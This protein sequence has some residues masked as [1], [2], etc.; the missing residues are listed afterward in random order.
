MVNQECAE[1]QALQVKIILLTQKCIILSVHTYF[2]CLKAGCLQLGN[3]LQPS[4][5][6]RRDLLSNALARYIKSRFFWGNITLECISVGLEVGIHLKFQPD[7][8]EGCSPFNESN[9]KE[10]CNLTVWFG[11]IGSS[12]FSS[13]IILSNFFLLF[14]NLHCPRVERKKWWSSRDQMFDMFTRVMRDEMTR[15]TFALHERAI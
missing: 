9:L 15:M 13:S 3:I 6:L 5:G 7:S 2:F 14:P 1:S 12:S 4:T 8:L 10:T 11:L